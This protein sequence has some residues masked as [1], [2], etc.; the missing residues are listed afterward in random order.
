MGFENILDLQRCL[1]LILLF[2]NRSSLQEIDKGSYQCQCRARSTHQVTCYGVLAPEVQ[3]TFSHGQFQRQKERRLEYPG[4]SRPG[5]KQNNEFK[6]NIGFAQN[7]FEVYLI[8][9]KVQELLSIK[10]ACG[11]LFA[12]VATSQWWRNTWII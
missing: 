4:Y 6:K 7:I 11:L 10:R 2:K 9:D 5:R 1:N 12:L 8:I 3:S